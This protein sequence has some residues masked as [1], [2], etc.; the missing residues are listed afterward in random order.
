M[1]AH[2]IVKAGL[3]LIAFRLGG[4]A[5]RYLGQPTTAIGDRFGQLFPA[6]SAHAGALLVLIGLLLAFSRAWSAG[7]R[8]IAMAACVVFALLMIAGQADLTVATITGAPLT[9]T[10]FRTFRGI[11]V[12]RSNE[13]LEPL[14]ANAALAGGGLVLFLALVAWMTRLIRQDWKDGAQTSWPE[15]TATIVAGAALLSLPATIT[16]PGPPPPIEVAFAREWLGL[17]R[18]SLRGSET[19]AIR[20][21]RAVVGLPA[22]AAWLSDE[23]PLVYRWVDPTPS[24]APSKPAAPKL[25]SVPPSEGGPDIVVVMIESLRADALGGSGGR[26][27]ATPNLDAL[28]RRSVVFPT[29]TSN[30]FPSAPSVLAFHCSAWPHRRKEI[31]TDFSDRRFDS[32]PSRLRDVGYD[33]TYIGADPHF[34]HQD[35]WLP[36]WYSTVIDL[37]ANGEA[38]TDRNILARGIGE[39]RRH[40]AAAP[41][42]PLFEFIS[43]YSTHYPFRL[44]DDAGERPLPTSEALEPRYRQVL[45]Y[46]DREIGRLLAFL[47]TRER[48]DRTIL[49][50]L[51][52]HGFYMDLRRTS[53]LPEN[54]N[55]WTTA[56][57]AG[58][59]RLVG[60]PRRILAPASHVDM[61]PTV[62]ALVGDR[63]PSAALGSDLFGPPRNGMRSAM[64]VRPGGVRLDREG[65]SILVDARTPTLA[66]SRVSFPGVMPATASA[67]PLSAASLTDVVADWSY[68][69]ERNRVWSPSF[70]ASPSTRR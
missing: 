68:L 17:D 39:I 54:D 55:I 51:G 29:F 66:I 13:F 3:L 64:A 37:V 22:G 44:P 7:R 53:G 35:H 50:V 52:D 25:E 69:I 21:L 49:I 30:G 33:T 57:I 9:P 4:V 56:I 65:A 47:E 40:D 38:P 5:V 15:A 67:V 46:T 23:Y 61:L 19:D 43:T 42:T 58:P 28:A 2:P 60:P 62:L 10:L 6:A 26:P 20:E 48:R 24:V 34:D 16:W 45:A 18:T 11:H 41:V 27:S 1:R 31:I 63:R 36:F 59:E 8:V 70:L 32:L 12:V 14:K